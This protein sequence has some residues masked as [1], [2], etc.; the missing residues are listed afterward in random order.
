[1]RGFKTLQ[2]NDDVEFDVG[3]SEEGPKAMNI[4]RV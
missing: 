2:E 4:R 3:E 1:M